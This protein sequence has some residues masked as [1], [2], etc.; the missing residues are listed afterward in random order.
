MRCFYS[1]PEPVSE[2]LK[3]Q[4][5][6]EQKRDKAAREFQSV[7]NECL[8]I[9]SDQ[10]G[11][12]VGQIKPLIE[13]RSQ[14]VGAALEALVDNGQVRLE[15]VGKAKKYFPASAPEGSFTL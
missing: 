10:P 6:T 9:I 3:A 14:T 4:R 15:E 12:K 7:Q 13:K 11:I 2:T 8:K 5:K 1:V